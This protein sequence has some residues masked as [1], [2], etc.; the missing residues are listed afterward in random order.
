MKLGHLGQAI[1]VVLAIGVTGC[2]GL[3]Q[4]GE[5]DVSQVGLKVTYEGWGGR[6]RVR[7]FYGVGPHFCKS[8]L[9]IY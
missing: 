6:G 7:R 1:L 2:S 5:S 8:G 3:A 9:W 4:Q